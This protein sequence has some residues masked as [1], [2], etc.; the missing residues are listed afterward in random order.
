MNGKTDTRTGKKGLTMKMIICTAVLSAALSF[1]CVTAAQEEG[2]RYAQ[3][4]EAARS[5]DYDTAYMYFNSLLSEY[6]GSAHREQAV[7]ALGEFSFL[8]GD[9]KAAA[10]LFT[11]FISEYPD[12][13][14]KVFALAYLFKIAQDQGYEQLVLRL[15]NEIVTYRQ[16]SLLFRNSKEYRFR[17]PLFR[18]HRVIYYIDKVEFYADGEL[19]AQVSY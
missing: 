6:P 4:E 9:L 15:K 18:K 3:A 1:S 11:S 10:T 14:G 2:M 17:S 19:F 12:A 13:K 8:R 7:F 16:L 5:K